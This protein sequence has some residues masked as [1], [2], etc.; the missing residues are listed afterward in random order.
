MA[1]RCFA[2]QV[3]TLFWLNFDNLQMLQQHD[4]RRIGNFIRRAAMQV[5]VHI[6]YRHA[7][8]ASQC[9]PEDMR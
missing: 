5:F 2:G 1:A 7:V 9:S 8:P 3:L 4:A 6:T